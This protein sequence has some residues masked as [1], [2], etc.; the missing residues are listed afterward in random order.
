MYNIELVNIGFFFSG[1]NCVL[2]RVVKELDIRYNI[3]I[4]WL[5]IE[6]KLPAD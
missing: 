3:M 4:D 6:M 5:V 2:T 1:S